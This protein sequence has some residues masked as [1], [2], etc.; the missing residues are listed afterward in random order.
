MIK[1]RK[2]KKPGDSLGKGLGGVYVEA[3]VNPGFK[4]DQKGF[5]VVHVDGR[6]KKIVVD[7]YSYDRKIG[8]RFLGDTAE[9]LCDTLIERGLVSHLEHSAYLGREL[10]KAEVALRNGLRYRQ[11]RDLLV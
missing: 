10:A 11:D 9:G 6:R 3:N 1:L 2:A 4:S 5:F 7:H 8:G